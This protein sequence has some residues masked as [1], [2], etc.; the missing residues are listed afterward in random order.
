MLIKKPENVHGNC[1][2]CVRFFTSMLNKKGISIC[3]I[4][5]TQEIPIM[6]INAIDLNAGCF[7]N[8]NTPKPVMVVIADR[9][10]DVL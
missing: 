6:E 4:I 8:T 9:K 5:T 10:I 2:F 3:D 1:F 7:A